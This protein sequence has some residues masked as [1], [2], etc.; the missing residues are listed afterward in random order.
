[1]SEHKLVTPEMRDQIESTIWLLDRHVLFGLMTKEA[2]TYIRSS[3][4]NLV[5]TCLVLAEQKAKRKEQ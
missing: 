3:L 4:D 2:E 5:Y 1:M